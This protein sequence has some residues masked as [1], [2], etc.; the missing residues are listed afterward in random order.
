MSQNGNGQKETRDSHEEQGR[1]RA[2]TITITLDDLEDVDK[3][4]RD[5][6]GKGRDVATS[7]GDSIRESINTVRTTRDSVVMVRLSKD[8]L[9]KLDE[10]VDSAVTNSR[11][12]AAAFL[13]GEGIKARSDLFDKIA[14]QTRVIREA[15]EKLR[16]LLEDDPDGRACP[17]PLRSQRSH[18]PYAE[19]LEDFVQH[20]LQV[21]PLHRLGEESKSL[22]PGFIHDQV[23][24][25]FTN[26]EAGQPCLQSAV[27]RNSLNLVTRL[28]NAFDAQ[29]R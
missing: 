3:A 21:V 5:A 13:I 2:R 29:S 17:S 28:I 4:V 20:P 25:V 24:V 6:L 14:E 22:P 12:E 27:G 9:E 19:L 16:K 8:S 11:S 7:V 1:K 26:S 10:L 23:N 18:C 15:R